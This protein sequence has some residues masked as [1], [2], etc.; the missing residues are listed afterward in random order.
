MSNIDFEA[1]SDTL[2]KPADKLEQLSALIEETDLIDSQMDELNEQLKSLASRYNHIKTRL[3]PD[4][5]TEL[6][7]SEWKSTSGTKIKID[8][9]V[10]ASFPK[11]EPARSEAVK[12]L[13][14]NGGNELIKSE[15]SVEFTKSQHNEALALADDIR[16]KGYAPSLLSSVHSGSLGAFVKEKMRNG[17]DVALE[18][19]GVY[20]AR[21]AKITHSNKNASTR[22]TVDKRPKLQRGAK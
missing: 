13:E 1:I 6:N 16:N 12:W 8:D 7:L 22:A 21:V 4:L 2:E 3:M 17:E 18:T 14:E 9:F 10:S 19:L 5:M 20:A 11:T 15:L